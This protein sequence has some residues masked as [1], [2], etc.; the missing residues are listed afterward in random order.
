MNRKIVLGCLGGVLFILT[1]SCWAA[2]QAQV[3]CDYDH[4]LADDPILMPGEP[5]MAMLH[6]FFGNKHTNANSTNASLKAHQNASCDNAADASAYWAPALKLPD[7]R[8]I[9]PAYQKTYYQANGSSLPNLQPFPEGIQILAGN[10][11]GTSSN[12]GVISFLC[13][14]SSY[15]SVATTNCGPAAGADH[16]QLDIGIMFPNCWDGKTLIPKTYDDPT[17]VYTTG[18]NTCPADHPVQLPQI[19]MNVAYIIPGTTPFDLSKTLL[20]LDPVM[21]DGKMQAQWGSIYTAHGDFMH[22]WT[23]QGAEFMAVLC[24]NVG[25]DC[26]TN[27][28]YAYSVA[29]DTYVSNLADSD[30]NFSTKTIVKAQDTW[31][32]SGP[33]NTQPQSIGL[34]KV[35]IPPLPDASTGYPSDPNVTLNYALRIYGANVSTS[36]SEAVFFHVVDNNWN[37]STVTWNTQPTCDQHSASVNPVLSSTMGW[38]YVDVTDMVKTAMDA[39]KTQISFCLT[40]AR[41][42]QVFNITSSEDLHSLV[43]MQRLTRKITSE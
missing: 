19:N 4:T 37:A 24:M 8:I 10:H 34:I 40:G 6:D 36:D 13:S 22:A 12:D 15:S 35:D 25:M 5:G 2:P 28:P 14:N 7:G 16:V 39:G 31:N 23:T 42:G 38:L 18:P 21:V 1:A 9:K 3:Q 30:K 27:I 20:S 41:E 33:D 43:L 17:L 29:Q 11:E 26:G 32:D